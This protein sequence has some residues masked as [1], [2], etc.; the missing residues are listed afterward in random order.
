M[1][2]ECPC[3][4]AATREAT[5][6]IHLF[7]SQLGVPEDELVAWELIAAEA[8]NNAVEYAAGDA[9]K[10]PVELAI[11]VTP[12]LIELRVFDHT[13]GFDLPEVIE[14]PD[15]MS[16]GGRGL[17]LM[18]TLSN[19]L[20]YLRGRKQNCL[21]I[22]KVRAVPKDVGE[23]QSNALEVATLE[24]TLQCMTEELAASY[25]SL[26]AIF[27]F[28]SELNRGGGG[29]EFTERWLNELRERGGA[30]WFVLRLTGGSNSSISVNCTSR[31][32]LSLPVLKLNAPEGS[33]LPAEAQ[34]AVNR[35]DVWFGLESPLAEND[36]L[37]LIGSPLSGFVHPIFV[38]SELE[39]VLAVG[40][41]T[42][43]QAF[44]AGQVNIIHTISDFLGIQL[45]N[46]RIQEDYLRG[47]LVT[48][49][50]EIA[51]TI[52]RS[53]LPVQLPEPPGFCLA[54]HSQSAS[55]VGGD[56]YDVLPVGEHGLLCIIADVMGKGVPAAMFAAIFRSHVR[57]RPD[58]AHRPGLFLEWL[59][60]VLFQDLD[61]VEMFI[62]AQLAFLDLRTRRLSVSSAGHCPLI[63]GAPGS[64][65]REISME[66]F[67][68][69]IDAEGTYGEHSE[70]L[71]SGSLAI[72]LTDGLIEAR[73]I[74]GNLLGLETVLKSIQSS[75][76]QHDDA[77]Q[78]C[79]ALV[80]LAA[81]FQGTAPA[82][83]DLTLLIVGDRDPSKATS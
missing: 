71:A 81:S 55:K 56:F 72:M 45:R 21:I 10:Q 50:L 48:R 16:E 18:S 76:H 43:T 80:S 44:N 60:A 20:E 34:A 35:Y 62:T 49:E 66:S 26:S 6:S 14:L 22:R 39:G 4:L 25:E 47:R 29:A 83:D 68:L 15:P 1:R 38:G 24:S 77:R 27:R 70:I 37:C 74:E 30:D 57:S 2:I 69:G 75:I 36:P 46:A 11:E 79:T 52:Q 51:A 78:T 64:D 63:I 41:Y 17:F 42:N 7:L 53:L 5:R 3:D 40:R 8:G 23:T 12:T 13:P 33:P 67:P 54:G 73:N 82:S 65:I 32:D 28:T 59:N 9:L 58:L 19:S 61:R 31:P